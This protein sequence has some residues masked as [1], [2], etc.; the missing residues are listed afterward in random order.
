MQEITSS[1]FNEISAELASRVDLQ[2]YTCGKGSLTEAEKKNLQELSANC[3]AI[4]SI[5]RPSVNPT[6]SYMTMRA[7]DIIGLTSEFDQY[8]FPQVGKPKFNPNQALISIG[9][10]GNEVGMGYVIEKVKQFIPN[11]EKICANTVCDHL[12]VNDTS[13][14]GGYALVNSMQIEAFRLYKKDKAAFI[15]LFPE[16]F[17]GL[18]DAL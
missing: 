2:C 11:G 16:S 6:G 3:D 15:K 9:D 5:E 18:I 12:L 7:I 17:I 13:N 10:G 8:L 14:F 1:Y 4:V